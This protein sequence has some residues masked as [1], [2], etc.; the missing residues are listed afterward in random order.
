MY[1]FYIHIIQYSLFI[2]IS[3]VIEHRA[4]ATRANVLLLTLMDNNIISLFHTQPA[5]TALIVIFNVFDKWGSNF[6]GNV[7]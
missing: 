3:F 1:N 2:H 4:P 5:Y 7:N 6:N